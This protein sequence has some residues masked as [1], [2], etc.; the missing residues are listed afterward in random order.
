VTFNYTPPPSNDLCSCKK[1]GAWLDRNDAIDALDRIAAE[2][3]TKVV[4]LAVH[5]C[6]EGVFHLT[7]TPDATPRRRKS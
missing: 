6:D 4:P 3:L 5:M 1:K 7:K 2:P